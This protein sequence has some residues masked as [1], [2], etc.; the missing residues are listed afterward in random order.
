MRL[1]AALAAILVAG[2]HSSAAELSPKVLRLIGPE[3]RMVTSADLDRQGKSALN[4]ILHSS[5]GPWNETKEGYQAVWIVSD[6]ADSQST[7]TVVVG[8]ADG[9]PELTS[10]DAN[11][12][13]DGD[14]NSISLAISRWAVDGPLNAMAAKVQ[15]LSRT[16][17]N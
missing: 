13:V 14:P 8:S 1:I 15:R 7:L 5:A 16:Y 2:L 17:D 12:R 3:T 9:I 10:L 11:T 6:S 4:M